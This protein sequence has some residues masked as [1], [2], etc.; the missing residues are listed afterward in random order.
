M[1]FDA[2]IPIRDT[3]SVFNDLELKYCLRSIDK[4]TDCDVWC[5]GEPRDWL[6]VN[7]IE[8]TD[9]KL[10]YDSRHEN[11]RQKILAAC[12]N[13]HV[14]DPFILFND[15][16]FLLRP[17]QDIPHY[18]DGTI[19]YRLQSSAGGYR[20]RMDESRKHSKDG[21]NYEL[22]CPVVIDKELF[23]NV[24]TPGSLY[25]NIYCSHSDRDKKPMGDV[26]MYSL[27]DHQRSFTKGKWCFSTND[28]SFTRMLDLMNKLYPEASK[29]E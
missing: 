28:F 15:D 7:W 8:E 4:H 22:H 27:E 24:T 29:W 14:S 5:I 9:E 20:D 12:N 23:K 19:E 3:P 17:I 11:V 2:V 13:P 26:K 16:F 25:R 10:N 18:Y 21:L 6:S 1:N